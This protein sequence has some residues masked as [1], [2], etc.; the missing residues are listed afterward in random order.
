MINRGMKLLALILVLLL[1]ACGPTG[2][3]NGGAKPATP[4]GLAAVAANGEVTLNWQANS[5]SDLLKYIIYYGLQS[6]N[7]DKKQDVA[8]D[9]TSTTIV[10]FSKITSLAKASDYFFAISAVNTSQKESDLS[11]EVRASTATN[12][13]ATPKNFKATAGNQK[14]S[15]SWSANTEKDLKQY[16]IYYG[17]NQNSLNNTKIAAKKETSLV[18]DSLQN[19]T[20]YFFKI[21]AENNIGKVSAASAIISAT[22]DLNDN[23]A[24]AVISVEPKDKATNV[25]LVAS[26]RVKFSEEMLRAN[27]KITVV[28]SVDFNCSNAWNS[29]SD[30]LSCKPSKSL[31]PSTTYQVEVSGEDLAGNKLNKY[32]FSFTT[33]AKAGPGSLDESFGEKGIFTINIG[34]GGNSLM[35]SSVIVNDKIYIA[36]FTKF[37]HANKEKYW[38]VLVRLNSDGTLDKS[39]D[40][41]GYKKYSIS[42]GDDYAFAMI[43]HAG[44]LYVVGGANDD[45]AIV[46]FNLDGSLNSSFNSTGILIKDFGD[47]AQAARAIT[48]DTQSQTFYIVGS[49][50]NVLALDSSGKTVN[51]FGVNGYKVLRNDLPKLSAS[52]DILVRKTKIY[53]AGSIN[54][55]KG[56]DLAIVALDNTGK[57]DMGFSGDGVV[58]TD[59]SQNN[60]GFAYDYSFGLS[61]FGDKLLAVG[62]RDSQSFA[63]AKYDFTSGNLDK[64]FG[65]KGIVIDNLGKSIY[66]VEID[67]K[68]RIVVLGDNS[69]GGF[70]IAR[71]LNTGVIDK[72]FGINGHVT[73]A[74]KFNPVRLHLDNN[75]KIIAQGSDSVVRVLP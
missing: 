46:S 28:S 37:M 4:Q 43:H 64:T 29:N 32:K 52:R 54:N 51:S 25:P 70:V 14:V 1:A 21:E 41:S 20:K 33:A 13:P 5:E 66:D 62:T 24:P 40:S 26:I 18:I 10:G 72:S 69:N 15:L 50:F 68:N 67:N 7:L 12:A 35:R 19:K 73:I 36:G 49:R 17:T 42:S 57:L 39:F 53:I 44:K 22:P 34:I 58:E 55:G 56:D 48:F 30:E 45:M 11:A 63:L 59:L 47:I 8:K 31:K 60:A 74:N 3:G 23:T 75:N 6:G 16:N 38:F 71:Y 9:K 65:N 61:I 27:T 2:T